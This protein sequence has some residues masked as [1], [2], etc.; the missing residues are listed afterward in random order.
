MADPRSQR[1]ESAHRLLTARD[2]Q[3][4]LEFEVLCQLP[5]IF[6]GKGKGKE[7]IA[8]MRRI[9]RSRSIILRGRVEISAGS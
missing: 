1:D 2:W 3:D 9:H 5:S 6:T 8:D 4:R 7:R